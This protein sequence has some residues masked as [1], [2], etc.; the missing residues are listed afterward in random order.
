MKLL[1]Q[2]GSIFATSLRHGATVFIC[3]RN[4]AGRVPLRVPL[5]PRRHRQRLLL[6]HPPHRLA[7]RSRG[8]QQ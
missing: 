5:K 4:S 7:S 1:G 8:Q 6:A 3:A 2:N